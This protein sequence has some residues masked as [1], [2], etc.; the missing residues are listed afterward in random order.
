MATPSLKQTQNQFTDNLK[1]GI[2][3]GLGVLVGRSVLGEVAGPIAGST[4]AGAYV[5][6]NGGD[7]ITINGMM[8]AAQNLG[9]T[10]SSGGRRRSGRRR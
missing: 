2:A 7:V 3:G 5:G 9:N 1:P 4:L 8:M 6:G 10:S